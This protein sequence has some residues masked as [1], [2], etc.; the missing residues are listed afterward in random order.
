[1]TGTD[2]KT[3]R[4]NPAPPVADDEPIDAEIVDEQPAAP[5]AKRRPITETARDAGAVI[6]APG[7]R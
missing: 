3:Y 2:G 1:V 5:G 6:T 4:P 7:R